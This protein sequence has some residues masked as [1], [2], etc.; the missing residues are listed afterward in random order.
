MGS[1]E[2]EKREEMKRE[3]LDKG[4]FTL[5]KFPTKTKEQIEKAMEEKKKREA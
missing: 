5:F 4:E 1:K 2:T 3:L